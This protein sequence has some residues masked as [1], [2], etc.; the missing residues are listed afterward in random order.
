MGSRYADG[1]RL[2]DE[3]CDEA[4]ALGRGLEEEDKKTRLT[5]MPEEQEDWEEGADDED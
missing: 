2:T 4:Y 3:I 5:G 1:L